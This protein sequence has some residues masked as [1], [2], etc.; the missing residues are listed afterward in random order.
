MRIYRPN[1]S[2]MKNL[3]NFGTI[4]IS[5]LCDNF[6]KKPKTKV[7]E[8][9]YFIL[10]IEPI[11]NSTYVKFVFDKGEV[12]DQKKPNYNADQMKIIC[13]KNPLQHIITVNSNAAHYFI[14]IFKYVQTFIEKDKNANLNVALEEVDGVKK[15]FLYNS[16]FQLILL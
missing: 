15:L 11:I 3:W 8:N 5:M 6:K 4:P 10:K 9:S 14:Q 2:D 13:V 12:L 16:C 7:L 1:I